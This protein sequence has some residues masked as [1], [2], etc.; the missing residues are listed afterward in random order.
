MERQSWHETDG[1]DNDSVGGASFT[2]NSNII[3]SAEASEPGGQIESVAF[4][5]NGA[6]LSTDFESPYS[7][8]WM[9]VPAGIYSLTAIATDDTNNWGASTPVNMTVWPSTANRP[10]VI[11]PISNQS[12]NEGERLQLTATAVDPDGHIVTFSLVNPPSGASIDAA[13]GFFSWM[14]DELQGPGLYT[15]TIRATDNGMPAL[16]ADTSFSVVVNE[17]N[18]KPVLDTI[19]AKS[20]TA[21]SNLTFTAS[22]SDADRPVNSLNYS[23]SNA[24]NGASI[25]AT[26]G[27]FTWTPSLAQVG[28][29]SFEVN[30][31]DNGT[32]PLAD[33]KSVSVSVLQQKLSDL[34]MTLTNPGND[35]VKRGRNVR[36]A[37]TI[38]NQGQ[39]V[40]G[41]SIVAFRL[42]RNA[43]YGDSDDIGISTTR[44]VA[45]LAAGASSQAN[46][47]IEIPKTVPVGYYFVCTMADVSNAVVEINETNNTLCSSS[48]LYVK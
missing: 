17:V 43:I 15:V 35:S 45:T 34:I 46:T 25:N 18:T 6:L 36:I 9:N 31:T 32:L 47:N 37:N 19:D 13:T 39:A 22:A 21:L 12:I 8:T 7:V 44:S 11:N 40:A 24:P 28:T 5:A 41:S 1:V 14:P 3:I 30:V 20:V 29:H 4:Y 23:L 33:S 10:P 38:L 48:Q 26:T 42:S 16:N 27:V 2:E